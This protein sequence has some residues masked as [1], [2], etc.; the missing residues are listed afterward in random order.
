MSAQG[1]TYMAASG[2]S[3]TTLEPY[4]Y[5]NYDPEVL[6]VGGTVATTDA[7]G[8]RTSEPGWASGGGG[9]S[10]NTATF[11]TL[12]SWQHGNG[13]ADIRADAIDAVLHRERLDGRTKRLHELPLPL[14]LWDRA[15]KRAGCARLRCRR[16]ARARR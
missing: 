7:S 9:W 6:M 10:T 11:N 1:I 4:S 12:P 2:D 8:N 5:P 14:E 13:V 15:T 3:G 16:S